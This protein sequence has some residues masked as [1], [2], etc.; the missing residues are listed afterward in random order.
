MSDWIVTAT[1]TL[2]VSTPAGQNSP[3]YA[4]PMAEGWLRAKLETARGDWIELAGSY[5]SIANQPA[6]I[7]M[8]DPET[9]ENTK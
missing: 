4:V 2:M 6:D 5:A 1:V 3:H 7:V 8:C 9:V